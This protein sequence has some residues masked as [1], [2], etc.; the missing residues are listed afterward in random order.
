MKLNKKRIKNFL[1]LSIFY[2]GSSFFYL[3]AQ[4]PIELI[5]YMGVQGGELFNYKL[6][7]KAT[8]PQKWEGFSYTYDQPHKVVK[9]EVKVELLED[10]NTLHI[11]EHK[12]IYND[13]FKS[14]ATICLLNANLTINQKQTEIKGPLITRT[15][16][17]Q[18]QCATGSLTFINE[19]EIAQLFQQGIT[20]TPETSNQTASKTP[21]TAGE[22][23]K[24][25][26]APSGDRA[27]AKLQQ[28]FRT[29][30][31][32]QEFE[33]QKVKRQE[34]RLAEQKPVQDE[35]TIGK[36]KRINVKED[37]VSFFIWDGGKIDYDQV[38]VY[39]NDKLILEKY[40]LTATPK[41]LDIKM[42][43]PQVSIKILAINEGNEPPNTAD[44]TLKDGKT[45]HHILSYNNRNNYS[46]ILLI[47]E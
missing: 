35:I 22:Q 2:I 16:I 24:R 30:S 15:D 26:N 6:E 1:L 19:Q 4:P 14:K 31:Q 34:A 44:I 25:I 20:Q 45:L 12:L 10:G 18:Y 21:N 37:V 39:V 42:D 8:A 40:T 32:R 13:G 9:A 41:K 33:A 5:G 36:A 23:I 29:Q 47:K 11:K 28:H 43:S 46:E 3:N 27:N 7:L 17:Q 38:N